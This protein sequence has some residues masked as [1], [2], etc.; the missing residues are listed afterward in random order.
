MPS[1]ASPTQLCT[2]ILDSVQHGLYPDSEDIITAPFPPS[3]F[4]D[5]LKLFDNARDQVKARV[6]SSS[7][8]SAQDI[9]GWI[10]QAKQLRKDIDTVQSFSRDISS[11]AQKNWELQRDVH[12]ASSKLHLLDEELAFNQALAAMIEDVRHVRR[13][14]GQIQDLSSQG[15]LLEAIEILVET[16]K[17]LELAEKG[18]RIKAFG[19]LAIVTK[20]LRQD[21]VEALNRRWHH[22]IR[23][24]AQTCTVSLPQ[25]LQPI[26]AIASAMENLGL[27]QEHIVDLTRQLELAILLPRLQLQN[28]THE[29]P[30]V[31]DGNTL[32]MSESASTSNMHR[33]IDDLST[34][35]A[36]L[37]TNLP[38]PIV[39]P[40]SKVLTPMLIERLIS[41]RLSTAIPE[42]LTALREFDSTRNEIQRFSESI[43]S[44][45]WPGQGQ[46]HAWIDRIPQLWVQ[47]RQMSSLDS[48][49]MLLHRGYGE[50]KTVERV[51]TQ[52]ISQQDRLFTANAHTDN[53]NAG[54]S[55][56]DDSSSPERRHNLQNT[57]GDQEEEDVSAWGLNDEADDDANTENP[58]T[59]A[60]SDVEHDAWGWGDDQNIVEGT[61]S[62]QDDRR[63]PSRQGK[64][65]HD[66]HKGQR[67]VTLREFYNITA[68][69]VGILDL[70]NNVISDMDEPNKQNSSRF[71]ADSA[72]PGLSAV[73]NLL[74]VMYRASASN[75]YSIN[76]NG[77]MFLYN[78][79]LW[80]V[81][82]L[83][84]IVQSRSPK[85]SR[86]RLYDDI[87]ALEAFGKRSYGREMESQRTIIKD[88]LDG[89]QGFVNCTEPPFSQE[90]DLAVRTIVDRLRDTHKQWK[91]VLSYS[92]LLQSIGSL[93]STVID[94]IIID[95]EDMSDISEPESQRLTAYCRQIIAVEELFLP[96]QSTDSTTSQEDA[97]PLTAVYVPGWI[98]FQYLSEILD[99]S[100]VD[101]KYLWTDGGLKLEYD[102]EEV[103][104]LIEA[105]FADSEH[106]RRAIGDIRRSSGR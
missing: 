58:A 105:L 27:L 64:I 65:G 89:A 86:L 72:V 81:D 98:R 46:L 23:I 2:A 13:A 95:V 56:E 87:L 78:D 31:V 54:W 71:P 96:Q 17:E 106:R 42:N 51:E 101:I 82:Q 93:L 90:C 85:Q 67:E 26:S 41:L 15:D 8:D 102:M 52:V 30:L 1:H 44:H 80:L 36:F 32:K 6:R 75:F 21:I 9:D 97:I 57:A 48:V 34:F 18:H 5:A 91:G 55:D 10:S 16:E 37:T 62:P 77:N 38:P 33:L 19:V 11:K 59:S 35:V 43:R 88:L 14:I 100:L 3:A 4:S 47:Q 66:R 22:S 103:V 60:E 50:T 39:D 79:C 49:R 73:P 29:R 99:S 28:G 45:G 69:P 63:K 24:D 7:K 74:L 83:R 61:L 12:D 104:E 84:R 70:I 76:N 20:D 92:A 53:W 68:L 94:K 40:L 25:N